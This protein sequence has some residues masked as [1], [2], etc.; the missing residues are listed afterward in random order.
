VISRRANVPIVP[1]VFLGTHVLNAPVPWVPFRS[2]PPRRTPLYIAYGRPIEP[3]RDEPCARRAR[4]L[5]AAELKAEFCRLYAELREQY[6][7]EDTWVP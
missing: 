1:C 5:Q 3:P 7:L 6:G 2:L 4:Q